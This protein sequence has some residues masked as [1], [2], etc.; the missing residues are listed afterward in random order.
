MVNIFAISITT[1][2]VYIFS[3]EKKTTFINSR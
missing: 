2:I 1:I 3:Y